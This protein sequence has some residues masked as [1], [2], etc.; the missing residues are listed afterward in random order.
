MPIGNKGLAMIGARDVGER[1]RFSPPAFARAAISWGSATHLVREATIAGLREIITLDPQR[2]IT[3][4]QSTGPREGAIIN[5]LY[6]DDAGRS[7]TRRCCRRVPV[8]SE[9]PLIEAIPEAAD[10]PSPGGTS[11]VPRSSKRCRS[12]TA[13]QRRYHHR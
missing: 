7:S 6:E 4:F 8:A 2:K 11:A 3:F 10:D 5:E 13:R 9:Q 1:A 12:G